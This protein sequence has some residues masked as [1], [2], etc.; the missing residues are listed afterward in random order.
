MSQKPPPKKFTKIPINGTKFTA[1][2]WI[3][4]DEI[5]HKGGIETAENDV[6]GLIDSRNK[7]KF[8]KQKRKKKRQHAKKSKGNV[9]VQTKNDL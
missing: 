8:K 1:Q 6:L 5:V 7:G 4:S 2:Q 9:N 3:H